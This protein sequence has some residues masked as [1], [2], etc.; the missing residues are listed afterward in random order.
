MQ[1]RRH[2]VTGQ[3]RRVQ[4]LPIRPLEAPAETNQPEYPRDDHAASAS[5]PRSR[6]N[7]RAAVPI[8]VCLRIF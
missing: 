7:I 3:R 5:L 8:P 2:Q 1:P 6:R 4:K